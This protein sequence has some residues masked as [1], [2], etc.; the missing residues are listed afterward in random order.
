MQIN[1]QN[2]DG[3]TNSSFTLTN[4]SKA[5]LWCMTNSGT[6]RGHILR[7]V[8]RWQKDTL[9]LKLVDYNSWFFNITS[10]RSFYLKTKIASNKRKYVLEMAKIL[11]RNKT[12]KQALPAPQTSKAIL[13]KKQKINRNN[14]SLIWYLNINFK[15][16]KFFMSTLNNINIPKMQTSGYTNINSIDL[17]KDNTK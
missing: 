15:N 13:I 12:T 8:E 17:T 16:S 5:R 6:P 11:R 1:Q 3:Y 7:P 14:H 9:S 2:N 10:Q 4:L